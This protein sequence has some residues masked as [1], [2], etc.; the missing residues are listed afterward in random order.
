MLDARRR[1]TGTLAVVGH[2]GLA[3][4]LLAEAAQQARESA[5][6]GDPGPPRLVLVDP[7]A[8]RVWDEHLLAQRGFG[9]T[10]PVDADVRETDDVAPVVDDLVG[11]GQ[12]AVVFAGEA[13]DEEQRLASRLGVLHPSVVV[14]TRR[15][16][17]SG[18]G[19]SPLLAQVVA[20]GTT[21]DAGEGRPVDRWERLARLAHES[22]VRAYPDPGN[23]GRLPWDGGL[24]AFHRES[25]VRQVITTLGGAVEAG[26]SWSTSTGSPDGAGRPSPEQLELMA[27]LEHESWRRHQLEHGVSRPDLLPWAELDE[28]NRAK[29]R[30]GVLEALELLATLGYRSFDDPDARWRPYRRHGE[31]T[32]VQRDED[33]TWTSTGG[34]EMRGHAGD[35][36][37]TDATGSRSVSA[38]IF[39]STHEHV[40]ADRY[41][42]VGVVDARRAVPGEDVVSPEGTATATAGQWVLRNGPEQWLVGD[43][44]FRSSHSPA[45]P[46]L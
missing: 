18:L 33:W 38:A 36:E 6:V 26:R 5:L 3:F 7:L 24:S 27:E 16:E 23:P 22:Y 44:H 19:D 12:V 1:G 11:A 43:A 31:V 45:D 15:A 34:A 39:P 2:S 13:D 14:Y 46:R 8:R 41:A 32:A 9:I 28:V 17:V 20:F 30:D 42:R 40:E 25:N 29:S 21:L 35:W 10:S 37:V 4:A